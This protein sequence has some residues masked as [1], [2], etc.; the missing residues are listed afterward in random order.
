LSIADRMNG[1][2][3]KKEQ[4]EIQATLKKYFEKGISATTASQLTGFNVK[5][6][7]KYF[8]DW[9]TQIKE[10]VDMD[11]LRRV[12]IERERY[13]TVLDNQLLKLYE[14]QDDME[15]HFIPPEKTWK[16]TLIQSTHYKER[17]HLVNMIC[18]IMEKKFQLLS[19]RP[20]PKSVDVSK[21]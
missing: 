2:P 20:K 14:L 11:F 16:S 21:N 12:K 4:L 3:S 10:I 13:I 8:E 7:C 18:Q 9:Y 19:Q 15:K 5:T 1:R 6:V 17:L